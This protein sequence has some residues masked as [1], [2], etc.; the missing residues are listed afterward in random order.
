MAREVTETGG[1]IFDNS[2]ELM[3]STRRRIAK[4]DLKIKMGG[5]ENDFN[6]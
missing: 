4:G 3:Q 2:K 5:R 6:T 1:T